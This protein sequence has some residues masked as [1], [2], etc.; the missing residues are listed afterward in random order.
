[1]IAEFRDPGRLP[2]MAAVLERELVA[3]GAQAG[4]VH[5]VE[6]PSAA[7]LAVLRCLDKGL[8]RR[9]VGAE[10]YISL[11]TVKTHIRDLY[12]KLGATSRE[13][14]ITRAQ[15]L[16]LLELTQSPG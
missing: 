3:A 9:E 11:N 12:R 7:E 16:G 14:A 8:S 4:D 13:D 1:M 6:Q 10:L 5:L 2:G 15:A